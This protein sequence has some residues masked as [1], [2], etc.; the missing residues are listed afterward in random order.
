MGPT[1]KTL[2]KCGFIQEKPLIGPRAGRVS[3]ALQKTLPMKFEVKTLLTG[4]AYKFYFLPTISW[5]DKVLLGRY[6]LTFTWLCWELALEFG[7]EE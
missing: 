7:R 3:P 6:E 4:T 1:R 5:T 2:Y